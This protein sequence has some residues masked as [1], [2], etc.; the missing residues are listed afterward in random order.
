MG[1]GGLR[2]RDR[3]QVAL[4]ANSGRNFLGAQGLLWE[5]R[6]ECAS[7]RRR[8]CVPS[9]VALRATSG[10]RAMAAQSDLLFGNT[11]VGGSN[12]GGR[13]AKSCANGQNAQLRNF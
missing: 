11:V 7:D 4:A 10:L 1:G 3:L 9:R 2:Q 12:P 5:V 13:C 8:R 6:A